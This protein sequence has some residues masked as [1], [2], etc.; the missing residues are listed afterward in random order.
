V[1]INDELCGSHL[2]GV[3]LAREK[4]WYSEPKRFDDRD[5]LQ[6][7]ANIEGSSRLSE[8]G[9]E[10]ALSCWYCR[11]SSKRLV[12]LFQINVLHQTFSH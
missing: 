7:A 12:V 1:I 9:M 8:S 11:H 2:T 4:G 6:P 5:G 10:L 3:S